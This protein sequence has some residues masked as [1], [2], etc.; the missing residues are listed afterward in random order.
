MNI[1]KRCPDCDSP[2]ITGTV[3]VEE[4][5]YIQ[6]IRCKKCG[7]ANHQDVGDAQKPEEP[8]EDEE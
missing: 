1:I 5:S 6:K 4:G 8:K 7:Y 3:S 2:R